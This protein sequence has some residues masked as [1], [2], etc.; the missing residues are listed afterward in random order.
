MSRAEA[1]AD[2]LVAHGQLLE[3][4]RGMLT[5]GQLWTVPGHAAG[6]VDRASQHLTTILHNAEYLIGG[7]S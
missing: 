7:A 6:V 3:L 5:D 1:M 2:L 4:V